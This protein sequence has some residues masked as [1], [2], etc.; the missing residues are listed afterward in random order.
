ML[1]HPSK[2]QQRLC[3]DGYLPLRSN[4]S[5]SNRSVTDITV[6]VLENRWYYLWFYKNSVCSATALKLFD[7]G[8]PAPTKTSV[9]TE[10]PFA[11]DTSLAA[12]TTTSIV[13][14]EVIGPPPW[15][16]QFY[17][18]R[19]PRRNTGTTRVFWKALPREKLIRSTAQIKKKCSETAKKT[20]PGKRKHSRWVWIRRLRF[21][22]LFDHGFFFARL[23]FG[24][25]C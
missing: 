14:P 17:T 22:Y 23:R 11:T 5:T 16:S 9:T 4:W 15:V 6:C 18:L 19:I 10:T 8:A 12:D 25:Q 3:M 24:V 21:G 1:V 20:D 7:T 13:T 2:Y